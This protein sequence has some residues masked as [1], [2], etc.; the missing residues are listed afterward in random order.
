MVYELLT[1]ELNQLNKMQYLKTLE[2]VGAVIGFL[3]QGANLIADRLQKYN[4][5]FN[6][7]YDAVREHQKNIFEQKLA[8]KVGFFIYQEGFFK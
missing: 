6:Y 8:G 3:V 5:Q 1:I 7:C 4:D 2:V